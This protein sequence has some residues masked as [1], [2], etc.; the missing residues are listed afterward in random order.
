MQCQQCLLGT[1]SIQWDKK[2]QVIQQG[3]YNFILHSKTTHE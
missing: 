1:Y 2:E 3:T